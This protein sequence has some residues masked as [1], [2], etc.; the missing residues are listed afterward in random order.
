MTVPRANDQSQPTSQA[1]HQHPGA[2][3]AQLMSQPMYQPFG[4]TLSPSSE[5][6][7]MGRLDSIQGEMTSISQAISRLQETVNLLVE[8]D[9]LPLDFMRQPR[10]SRGKVRNP[11]KSDKKLAGIEKHVDTAIGR[12]KM[13]VPSNMVSDSWT[14]QDESIRNAIM[15]LFLDSVSKSHPFVPLDECE[16]NWI[17]RHFL[18][19]KWNNIHTR[20]EGEESMTMTNDSRQRDEVTGSTGGAMSLCSSL[21]SREIVRQFSVPGTSAS[22]SRPAAIP[23]ALTQEVSMHSVGTGDNASTNSSTTHSTT[24]TPMSIGTAAIKFKLIVTQKSC[25]LE[26]STGFH[27][28]LQDFFLWCTDRLRPIHTN[29]SISA[30]PWYDPTAARA[31]ERRY[32]DAATKL[33]FVRGRTII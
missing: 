28:I 14:S 19:Q 1:P 26:I 10:N 31:I 22:R 33:A 2:S 30:K 3:F 4:P 17:T 7:I 20:N 13:L 18:V 23:P 29:S 24:T 16:K 6:M 15:K 12:M 32:M 21:Q 9:E 11:T 5:A 27:R 25:E 8:P